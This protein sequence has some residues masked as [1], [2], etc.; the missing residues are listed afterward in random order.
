MD[1]ALMASLSASLEAIGKTFADAIA[2]SLQPT[3]DAMVAAHA[4]SARKMVDQI[5]RSW[6]FKFPAT[7]TVLPA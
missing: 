2:R 1:A 3:I 4:E 6:A 5:A 7:A